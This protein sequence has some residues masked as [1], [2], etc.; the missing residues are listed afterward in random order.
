MT[1]GFP[2]F[3]AVPPIW[4]MPLLSTILIFSFLVSKFLFNGI[5]SQSVFGIPISVSTKLF[6]KIFD[7]NEPEDVQR[8]I[9]LS[10]FS[11]DI[12]FVPLY[13]KPGNYTSGFTVYPVYNIYTI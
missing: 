8:V 12:N 6:S 2:T 1:W 3:T 11:F 7:F 13:K 10:L 5:L 9:S 4:F